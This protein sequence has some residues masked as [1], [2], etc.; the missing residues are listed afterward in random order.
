MLDS[1]PSPPAFSQILRDPTSC[2][3]SLMP[4]YRILV[5]NPDHVESQLHTLAHLLGGSAEKSRYYP[6]TSATLDYSLALDPMLSRLPLSRPTL[7][8]LLEHNRS[9]FLLEIVTDQ[10]PSDPSPNGSFLS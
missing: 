2:H 7:V 10:P 9:V 6:L 3:L 5:C 1:S 4:L 8:S